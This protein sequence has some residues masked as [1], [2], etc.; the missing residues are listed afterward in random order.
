MKLKLI[1]ASL[2]SIACL[3]S[4]T[5]L[6]AKSEATNGGHYTTKDREFYMTPEELLFVRPG[7]ELEI[8]DVIIP[9]DLLTEV[10]FRITDPAGLPLDRT[11]VLPTTTPQGWWNPT[12]PEAAACLSCHDDDS[13]AAHA[14]SNTTFFGEGC[15]TCHGEGKEWSV[16]KVHAQ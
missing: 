7:L 1:L 3:C 16:D 13:S 11:G 8:L 6:L 4:A 2:V 9:A 10:T 5:N 14:Y 12:G 15:A